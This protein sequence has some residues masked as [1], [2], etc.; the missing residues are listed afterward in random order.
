[1]PKMRISLSEDRGDIKGVIALPSD[2][3]FVLEGLLMVLGAF[4]R[5]RGMK[6]TEVLQD[7]FTMACKEERGE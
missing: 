4:S 2:G 6:T 3:S 1:M 5:A 7:L